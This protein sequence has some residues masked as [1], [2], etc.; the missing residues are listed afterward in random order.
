MTLPLSQRAILHVDM[1]AFFAAIEQRRRPEYRGKPVVVA[2]R[3]DPTE[4]GVVSTCSY[5]ARRYGIRSAM[6][7]RTA[8]KRC[9][10]AIFLPVDMEAYQEES[11]RVKEI[12]RRFSD[13]V[14]DSSIDEAYLDVTDAGRPATEVARALKAAV[15]AETGLTCSVGVGPNRLLAKIASDMDKP[16]GL[17]VLAMDDV[18]DRVWPLPVRVLWGVGPKTAARLAPLGIETVGDLARVDRSRLAATVGEST[19]QWLAALA[20]GE[21]DSPIETRGERKSQSREVTF[22]RDIDDPDA[23]AARLAELVDGVAEDARGGGYLARTVTVKVR[24]VTFTTLTRS[25]TLPAATDDA[26]VLRAAAAECLARVE[27]RRPVRL[28]GCALTN[29][30]RRQR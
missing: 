24:F 28:I 20:R 12:L 1:D 10:H 9:P 2:G 16:D 11:A 25:L 3:G 4:R 23:L 27:L 15:A 13:V 21:D 5:E 7:L 6:P 30:E 26:A 29:L 8:Y 14:G 22:Q 18:P 17:T 19:A